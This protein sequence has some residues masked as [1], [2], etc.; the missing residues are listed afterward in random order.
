MPSGDHETVSPTQ[1]K[2]NGEAMRVVPG[3]DELQRA[4]ERRI[5]RRTKVSGK[6]SLPAAPALMDYYIERITAA[7]AAMGKKFSDEEA[8]ILREL[9]EPRVETAWEV[10]PHGRLILVGTVA[11][12]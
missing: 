11:S 6:M 12:L 8:E 1:K 9:I 5:G 3:Q 10:S 2:L 4:L 7:F